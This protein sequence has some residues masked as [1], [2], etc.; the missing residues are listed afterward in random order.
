MTNPLEV[1]TLREEAVAAPMS[2]GSDGLEERFVATP[3]KTPVDG[4]LQDSATKKKTGSRILS[5]KYWLFIRD[6]YNGL[7]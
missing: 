4:I 2:L 6:P 1:K 7:L 5:M 3:T